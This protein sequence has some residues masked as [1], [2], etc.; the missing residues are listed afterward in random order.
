MRLVWYSEVKWNY[1]QTRKQNLLK[2]F[3]PEDKI[4]FFQPFSFV[5][6]NYFLPRKD[7]NV[8]YLTLPTYRK[9]RFKLIDRIVSVSFCRKL[10]YT[11]LK[12][13]AKLWIVLLFRKTPDRVCIS[14]LFYLPLIKKTTIPVVWDFND[15][16]Q[17]F[18]AQ[19][20][21]ALKEF[22]L[23]LKD[24][25]NS[26]IS[27][28]TGITEYINKKYNRIVTTIPNGVDLDYFNQKNTSGEVKQKL[29][30]GY[31]GIISPWFFDFDL[32]RKISENFTNCE[33]QLIGPCVNE[34]R[35]KLNNL[36]Q[37]K[38]INYK[39]SKSYHLLPEIMKGFTVGIIPLYS[40]PEVWRLA[41]GK[42]LQYLS[43]GIPVVSVWM[44]QFSKIE[45]NVYLSKSHNEFIDGLE[46]AL[47]HSFISMDDQLIEYDWKK[48]AKK[49]RNE[50]LAVN[51]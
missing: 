16:P 47:K 8:Y 4:L 24:S 11:I 18:G 15:H 41:S 21:W 20:N 42:F 14:N 43:A 25:R 34:V 38:N 30:I 29:I 23:F 28:S 26:I 7:G 19:P 2:Y 50:L 31:V 35:D 10:F 3:P 51:E 46:K 37:N 48:L 36:I 32:L 39:G 6:S 5:G 12:G 27:S 1:L 22:D 9:S 17:Q 13:N 45:K 33:I 44:D 49:F 40:I